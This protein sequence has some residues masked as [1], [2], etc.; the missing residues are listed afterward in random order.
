[1]ALLFRSYKEFEKCKVSGVQ[2]LKWFREDEW[3]PSTALRMWKEVLFFCLVAKR[4]KD[5]A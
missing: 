3:C 4:A 5:Q 2:G 1:M